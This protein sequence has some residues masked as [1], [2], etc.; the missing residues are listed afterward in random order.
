M[1]PIHVKALPGRR[2]RD[3]ATGQ[4]LPDKGLKVAPSAFWDR[5][6]ADA[7]VE[8]VAPRAAKKSAPTSGAEA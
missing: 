4:P 1:T 8:I 6:I 5:R 2:V 7:D 3:P